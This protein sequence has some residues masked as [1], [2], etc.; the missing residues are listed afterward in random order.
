MSY[1]EKS[2]LAASTFY[3]IKSR[4]EVSKFW[5]VEANRFVDIDEATRFPTEELS[6]AVR[7]TLTYGNE[8]TSIR[9]RSEFHKA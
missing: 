6:E 5:N 4:E 3:L 8:Y 2:F 1:L 9:I 7:T